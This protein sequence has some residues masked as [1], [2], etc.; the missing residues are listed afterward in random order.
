MCTHILNTFKSVF[1]TTCLNGP[2]VFRHETNKTCFTSFLA[3]S[4]HIVD[5]LTTK[6]TWF[7]GPLALLVS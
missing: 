5:N 2:T 3:N 7:Y 4:L 1:T 6:T